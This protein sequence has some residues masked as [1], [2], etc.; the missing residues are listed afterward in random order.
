MKYTCL[1]LFGVEN[2]LNIYL[3]ELRLFLS[4]FKIFTSFLFYQRSIS[5]YNC[6]E[7]LPKNAYCIDVII[8]FIIYLKEQLFKSN[9]F[10]SFCG[11]FCIYVKKNISTVESNAERPCGITVTIHYQLVSATRGFHLK[12]FLQNLVFVNESVPF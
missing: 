10:F 3:F 6:L 7:L 8:D 4:T 2:V 5:C 11:Y 12:I 1:Q 9:L